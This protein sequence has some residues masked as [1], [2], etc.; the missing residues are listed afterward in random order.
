MQKTVI[1]LVQGRDADLPPGQ[2]LV[3]TIDGNLQDVALAGPSK[4]HRADES[5]IHNESAPAFWTWFVEN[6]R[7]IVQI[8]FARD[9][10]RVP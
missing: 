1:I 7:P 3:S 6:P 2:P 9:T 5:T 10:P 8:S 4:T